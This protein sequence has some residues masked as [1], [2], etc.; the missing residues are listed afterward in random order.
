MDIDHAAIKKAFVEAY[1][2]QNSAMI[3]NGKIAEMFTC[4]SH[5][6][7]RLSTDAYLNLPQDVQAQLDK[8]HGI[9][10]RFAVETLRRLGVPTFQNVTVEQIRNAS[11]LY[12]PDTLKPRDK[13]YLDVKEGEEHRDSGPMEYGM[14]TCFSEDV[15][16]LEYVNPYK[17]EDFDLLQ[18]LLGNKPDANDS[19]LVEKTE[20]YHAFK[21]LLRPLAD[22]KRAFDPVVPTNM[23]W[24][25]GSVVLFRL[26]VIHRS[27]MYSGYRN[28][29]FFTISPPKST[30]M[31]QADEQ[32]TKTTVMVEM[33]KTLKQTQ[34]TSR[35]SGAKDGTLRQLCCRLVETVR[36][37]KDKCP[38]NRF[39]QSAKPW[40]ALLEAFVSDEKA[41]DEHVNNLLDCLKEPKYL[42]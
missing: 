31:Y 16:P 5:L 19:R 28:H 2:A 27:P 12:T 32:H 39:K 23:P 15:A 11:H 17:L 40:A 9:A 6:L 18:Y 3:N 20:Q 26:D 34:E 33:I 4:P 22:L 25:V 7:Q 29:Y 14:L 21:D 42:R 41:I 36:E 24:T 1:R 35:I 13:K 8:A 37:Y 38:W 30:N 10:K